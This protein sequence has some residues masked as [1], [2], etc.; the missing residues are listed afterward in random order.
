MNRSEHFPESHLN[1]AVAAVQ[2]GP[3]ALLTLLDQLPVPI[4]LT[5]ADGVV[6]HFNAACVD[7]A[8]RQPV[9]GKDRW[10]VTW[11][12]YASDG[13][14]MPHEQCPMAQAVLEKRSVR[15]VVAFAER[16]DGT[17]VR[18]LPYPTPIFGEDGEL[19]CAVNMLIDIS[20]GRQ[21]ASL[22]AQAEKCRRH[23]R[24]INDERAER[25]LMKLA[26]EYDAKAAELDRPGY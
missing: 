19:R 25:A 13:A 11:R 17:R 18:F 9:P 8:G 23:A 26:D 2:A 5:D 3:D 15:G 7:F 20:D 16:P 21:A 1:R 14:F 10:C 6:T 24:T 22:R 12:L 4:Y